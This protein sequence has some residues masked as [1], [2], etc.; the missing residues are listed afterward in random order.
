MG[1]RGATR[2]QSEVVGAILIFAIIVAFIGINQAFLVPQAN[3]DV[4]FKHS[5]D[6]QR[7]MV[8]LRSGTMEAAASN[9][10]RS[11]TIALGTD[12]PSRFIAINP[13]PPAGTLRT[14]EG[15][16]ITT[17]ARTSLSTVCGTGDKEPDTQFLEYEPAYNEYQNALP[18]TLENG[19]VYRRS[20]NDAIFGTNQ[21]LVRGNQINIVRVVGD[22][23]ETDSGTVSV[24]LVPSETGRLI[25]ETPPEGDNDDLNVTV[26][27]RLEASEWNQLLPSGAEASKNGSSVTI[28]LGEP[29]PD[30]QYVVKC[31]TV[32]INEAP[33]VNPTSVE[34]GTATDDPGLFNP[35]DD[36]RFINATAESGGTAVEVRMLNNRNETVTITRKRILH[37]SPGKGNV[38]PETV[39]YNGTTLEIGGEAKAVDGHE[40]DPNESVTFS[41][42]FETGVGNSN[43]HGDGAWYVMYIEFEGDETGE[44][45]SGDYF[46]PIE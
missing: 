22:V 15:G 40:I 45:F 14:V 17:N 31:T 44:R 6:V 4:E 9:E 41:H 35:L 36:V 42:E 21:V 34:P 37:Y 33:D 43:N 29:S 10:P 5:N 32:G 16:S 39:K 38:D 23:R 30:N 27:S 19:V 28:E 18:S 3:E 11:R 2:G 1:F 24:D 20:S 13:S 26:P 46:V 25:V 8:E 12:Y 7:D